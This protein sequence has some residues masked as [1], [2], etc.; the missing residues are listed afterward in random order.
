[1]QCLPAGFSLA[2]LTPIKCSST[3]RVA[4]E[5]L[6]AQMLICSQAAAHN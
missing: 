2:T 5:H 3:D 4:G 1:M 6:C